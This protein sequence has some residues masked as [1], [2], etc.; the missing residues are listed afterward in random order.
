MALSL[1]DQ[2]AL[3]R[4][5]QLYLDPDYDMAL[6]RYRPDPDDGEEGDDDRP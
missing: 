1:Q 5:E 3:D 4:W 2:I 6:L